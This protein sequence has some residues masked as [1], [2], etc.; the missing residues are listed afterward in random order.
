MKAHVDLD[1]CDGYANCV[2]NAD[3]IFDIEDASGQAVV[4]MADIP[5]ELADEL[6]RA[7]VSCP[8]QAITVEE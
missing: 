5:V 1:R 8:A 3:R 2:L 6:H 4:L 7:A